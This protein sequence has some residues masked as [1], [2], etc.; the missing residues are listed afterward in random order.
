MDLPASEVQDLLDHLDAASNPENEGLRQSP[1]RSYRTREASVHVLDSSGEIVRTGRV[2]TRNISS[3]GISFLWRQMMAPGQLLIVEL[4]LPDNRSF[5][6]RGKVARCRY[7]G[8]MIHEV[9]VEFT[10]F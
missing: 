3:R 8:R 1:R 7:V 9:G 6:L 10:G 5:R 4:P 2:P